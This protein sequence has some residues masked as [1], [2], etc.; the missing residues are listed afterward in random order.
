MPMKKPK[1]TEKI[2]QK[3]PAP[4][5]A[6]VKAATLAK[7]LNVSRT[8]VW[9]WIRNGSIKAARGGQ[10]PKCHYQIPVSVIRERW[11]QSVALACQDG[12]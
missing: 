5:Q 6:V 11:G 4:P 10:G 2:R 3:A 7:V 12:R 8:T 9:N 1:K